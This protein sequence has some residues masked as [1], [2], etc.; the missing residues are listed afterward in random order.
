MQDISASFRYP[1]ELNANTRLD[2]TAI[3]HLPNILAKYSKKQALAA[4]AGLMTLPQFQANTL[5]R[6]GNRGG[7]L[8]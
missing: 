7:W 6:P 8:V 2:V 1:F 3:P 5:N 4:V